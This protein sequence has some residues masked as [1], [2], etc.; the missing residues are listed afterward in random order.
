MLPSASVGDRGSGKLRGIVSDALHKSVDGTRVV[1]YVQVR[2]VD[3]WEKFR[4]VSQ[5]KGYFDR[6]ANEVL[7]TRKRV[8]S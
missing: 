3:D 8:A 2:S 7:D 4:K 1:S 5:T 6:I